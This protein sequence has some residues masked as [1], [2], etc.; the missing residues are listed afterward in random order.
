[1]EFHD[2]VRAGYLAEAVLDPARWLVVDA[3]RDRDEI[4]R[5]IIGEV[6]RRFDL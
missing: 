4:T 3:S 6:K 2:S 1:M 5:Q